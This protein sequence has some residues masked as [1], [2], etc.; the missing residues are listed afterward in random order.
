MWQARTNCRR[1]GGQVRGDLVKAFNQIKTR[2]KDFDLVLLETT[3]LA[4]PA[5]V[6][7][8]ITSDWSLMN[9]FRIDGKRFI[10]PLPCQVS[11]R[12]TAQ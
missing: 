6:I 2:L 9:S 7:K 10:L 4:D 12:R 5:P 3:G 8:T 1:S 11:S